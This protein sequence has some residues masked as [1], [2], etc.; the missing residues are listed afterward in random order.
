MLSKKGQVRLEDLLDLLRSA[1]DFRRCGAVVIFAGVVRGVGRNGAD[2][3]LLSYEVYEEEALRSLN[4]IREEVMREIEGVHEVIINHVIDDLE[5]GDEI[6]HV[7]VAAEHRE[8][9]FLAAKLIVDRLK[10]ETPIWKKEIT[11]KGSYWVRES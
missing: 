4:R 2:V 3:K 7:L 10:K 6:L 8:E 11:E 5:V 9:A 1:E